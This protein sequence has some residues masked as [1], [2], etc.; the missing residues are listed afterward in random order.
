MKCWDDGTS[1]F[2]PWYLKPGK[3]AWKACCV[4]QKF[5]KLHHLSESETVK[6]EQIV[7]FLTSL[8][9][10]VNHSYMTWYILQ[11]A[12]KFCTLCHN[13]EAISDSTATHRTKHQNLY[14]TSHLKNSKK[15]ALF[16][17][18]RY[19]KKQKILHPLLQPLSHDWFS[20]DEQLCVK[21]IHDVMS[22]MC[23]IKIIQK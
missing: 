18:T 8:L 10:S 22:F 4:F 9:W 12:K 1:L 6:T 7:R 2:Y 3:G 15:Y 20:C 21:K 19:C 23:H 17:L 13:D 5:A 14:Y 11:K 16:A